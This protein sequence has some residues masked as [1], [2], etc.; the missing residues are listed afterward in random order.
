VESACVPPSLSPRARRFADQHDFHPTGVTGSGPN[1]RILESDLRKLYQPPPPRPSGIRD[2]IARRMR[3]SLATTAQY[4]L[5]ASADATGLL[6][7]RARLKSSAAHSAITIN[8]LVTLCVIDALLDVPS[9]NAHYVDGRIVEHSD[10]HIGFACD[11][12]R[13]LLVPVIRDAHTLA[14]DELAARAR[15]LA[16]QAVAGAISP[17]DL[18][19]AT[20]TISNL[21][22]LG[23]ETFTPLLNPPQVAILGV[24]AIQ[25]KPIRRHG[26]ISFIDAITLSLTCDHQVI[27]GAP[28]ARFLQTVQQKIQSV[29][30]LCAL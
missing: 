4:T 5:H 12:P 30:S 27:D 10:I 26:E 18:S 2:R 19:G 8:D 14:I 25:V 29:E 3:E 13:G 11:T 16:A 7:L 22:G 24:G 15:D 21:G 20:F 9:L 28:G 6:A 23:I 17:D 1:G